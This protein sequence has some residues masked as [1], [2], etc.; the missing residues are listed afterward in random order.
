MI[1]EIYRILLVTAIL[2]TAITLIAGV[3][4]GVR[5]VEIGP[6]MGIVASTAVF[7]LWGLVAINS[8]NVTVFSGGSEFTR[9]YAS[10]AWV[11]VAGA[12]VSL[13]S[14]LQ[15]TLEE[16]NNSGGI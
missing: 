9:S 7:I 6:R 1:I 8:F 16:I 12:G 2:G 3:K 4:G 10:V 11:A 15:A 14:M 5:G 13:I